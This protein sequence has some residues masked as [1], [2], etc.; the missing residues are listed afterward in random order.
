MREVKISHETSLGYKFKSP[1]IREFVVDKCTLVYTGPLVRGVGW[2]QLVRRPAQ[3]K[4][5]SAGEG[6]WARGEGRGAGA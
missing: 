2:A 3:R 5:L 4:Q 1:L 6:R